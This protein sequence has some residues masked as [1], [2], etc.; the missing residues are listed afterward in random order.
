MPAFAESAACRA[1]ALAVWKLLYDP[2]RFPDWWDGTGRVE[3]G[4]GGEVTRFAEAWPDFPYPT[5]VRSEGAPGG[6]VVISCLVSGISQRWTLEPHPGGCAVTVTVE[7]P[8]EEA[9]RL[10]AQRA[11]VRASLDRLVDL[12]QREA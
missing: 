10:S 1:P 7:L 2:A 4:P 5:Q 9:G 6:R 3:R 11:E 8:A 12:A